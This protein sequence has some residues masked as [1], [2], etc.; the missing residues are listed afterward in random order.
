MKNRSVHVVI[1]AVSGIMTLFVLLL[2]FS[3]IPDRMT[4]FERLEEI[5]QFHESN[6]IFRQRPITT[7][8]IHLVS[9]LTSMRMGKSFVLVN[10]SFLLL[11][12][13]FIGL[14][15]FR[16]NKSAVLSSLNVVLFFLTFSNF[17]IFFSPI[18]TYDE[19][20]QYALI[21]IS[22]IALI[23]NKLLGFCI[24][25]GMAMIAK[26]TS[27]IL[28]PGFYLLFNHFIEEGTHSKLKLI[29]A[30]SVPVLIY[31]LFVSFWSGDVSNL[32]MGERFE[33]LYYNFQNLQYGIE[34]ILSFVMVAGLSMYMYVRTMR[35][36][37]NTVIGTF[38]NAFLITLI[39]NSAM[40][41]GMAYAR[42]SRLF[43]LP[44][45]FAWPVLS[46]LFLGKEFEWKIKLNL[47]TFLLG[48]ITVLAGI[49]SYYGVCSIYDPVIGSGAGG[50]FHVY[51]SIL[52]S[53]LFFDAFFR[54]FRF[55][56]EKNSAKN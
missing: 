18:Y 31:I 15:S 3:G 20:I 37:R 25:F 51:F 50:Y 49:V 24:L 39:I 33:L 10:F 1:L 17:F 7:Y 23:R 6:E 35:F 45:F 13:Y 26:E 11:S 16:F 42:E 4:P 8:L 9:D 43:A 19:P 34:S 5:V 53:I 38:R 12:G 28:L 44:L 54:R 48:A 47:R 29:G 46:T 52:I 2:H 41:F 55:E 14:I 21:L 32:R 30:F 56:K 40:V 22:F 36:S 27:V